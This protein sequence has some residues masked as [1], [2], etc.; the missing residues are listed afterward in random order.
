MQQLSDHGAAVMNN[1]A[2]QFGLSQDAVRCMMDAISAGGGNQAQ[3]SHPEVGGM[4]QWQAGGMVMV[5]DMFNT[6][7]QAMVSN[8]CQSL[9]QSYHNGNFYAPQ[10]VKG[11][12][13]FSAGGAQWWPADLGQP[14]STGMQNNMGYAVFPQTARLATMLNGD[15]R[16][17]DTGQH[18]IG[19]VSQQQGSGTSVVFTSQFGNISTYDLVMI[20]GP[21][22]LPPQ[23]PA[24]V[25]PIPEPQAPAAPQNI[26]PTPT[27]PAAASVIDQGQILDALSKLGSLRDQ[28]ILTEDEFQTKKIDLLSRL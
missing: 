19:G 24:Q 5:G 14:S 22:V 7:L 15:V 28:G 23:E 6:G 21:E 27:Q 3:F 2:Q 16:V 20:A 13:G 10:P 26:T 1:T 8:L 17:F 25:Q 18:M 11:A 9:A 12:G 4:G